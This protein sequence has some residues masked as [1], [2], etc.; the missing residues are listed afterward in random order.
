MAKTALKGMT[1]EESTFR[2]ISDPDFEVICSVELISRANGSANDDLSFTFDGFLLATSHNS[3][4]HHI[5]NGMKKVGELVEYDR[6]K[7]I[8]K[9]WEGTANPGCAFGAKCDFSSL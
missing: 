1:A 6:G 9:K 2:E 5:S 3:F 4:A 7:V 8:G